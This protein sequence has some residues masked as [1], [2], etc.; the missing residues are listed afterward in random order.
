[1]DCFSDEEK[2]AYYCIIADFLRVLLWWLVTKE[3]QPKAEPGCEKQ[4]TD[5]TFLGALNKAAPF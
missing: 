2:S 1:M 5:N 4:F 3:K